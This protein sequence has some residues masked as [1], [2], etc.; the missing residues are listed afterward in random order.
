MAAVADKV[1]DGF[2]LVD[3]YFLGV[4]DEGVLGV[5]AGAMIGVG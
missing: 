4:F 2:P 5:V 1:V 3:V